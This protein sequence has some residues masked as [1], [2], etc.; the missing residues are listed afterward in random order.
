MARPLQSRGADA[1]LAPATAVSDS[2]TTLDPAN[3]PIAS[4]PL[5]KTTLR[6]E[7]RVMQQTV[8]MPRAP[9]DEASWITQHPKFA[10]DNPTSH[11]TDH[12]DTAERF[13]THRTRD[14]VILRR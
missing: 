7:E 12:A 1:A 8:P 3:A 6:V 10:S 13:R 2:T 9:T 14:P 11:P 4:A 5:A